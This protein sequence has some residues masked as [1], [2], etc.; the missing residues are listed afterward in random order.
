MAG[1]GGIVFNTL[2]RWLHFCL[3]GTT[4][5]DWYL[6]QLKGGAFQLKL[7]THVNSIWRVL[8]QLEDGVHFKWSSRGVEI[9]STGAVE[10]T[11]G[12]YFSLCIRMIVWC[13]KLSAHAHASARRS[14]GKAG[15]DHVTIATRA[16]TPPSCFLGMAYETTCMHVCWW[17]FQ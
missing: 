7:G 10:V 6:L 4:F 9:T 17:S 11:K 14:K 16:Q 2:R 1:G 5:L 12:E 8:L 3:E 13:R 15:R